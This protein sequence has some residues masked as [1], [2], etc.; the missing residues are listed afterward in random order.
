MQEQAVRALW[1]LAVS[2]EHRIQIVA[3]GAIPPMVGLLDSTSAAVNDDKEVKIVVVGAIAPL[4]NLLRLHVINTACCLI[5][6]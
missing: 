1:N 5:V 3:A 4:G 6:V 2:D